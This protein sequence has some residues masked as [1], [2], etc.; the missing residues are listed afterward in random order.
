M[1]QLDDLVMEAREQAQ[2]LTVVM[3]DIDPPSRICKV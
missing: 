1:Q 3:F 2:P